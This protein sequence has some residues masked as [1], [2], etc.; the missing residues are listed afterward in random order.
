MLK[1][2]AIGILKVSG[3]GRWRSGRRVE[4]TVTAAR[5]NVVLVERLRSGGADGCVDKRELLV[6][7]EGAAG[8]RADGVSGRE[9]AE[10]LAAV[11][12]DAGAGADDER[13]VIPGRRPRGS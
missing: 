7:A 12:I 10:Q 11:V 3:F 13:I 9:V 4:S 1:D 5:R 6:H 8:N 2:R